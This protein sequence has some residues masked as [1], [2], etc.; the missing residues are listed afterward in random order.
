MITRES[1]YRISF[2]RSVAILVATIGLSF[3]IS[4]TSL[5]QASGSIAGTVIDEQ[6]GKIPGADLRLRSRGGAQFS[7]IT[8]QNGSFAFKNIKPGAYQVEVKARGF[9][10]CVLYTK[11]SP[12]DRG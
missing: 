6:G 1:D 12:R 8:D 9:Y 11:P 7:T 5:A 3:C 4:M 2:R 10:T